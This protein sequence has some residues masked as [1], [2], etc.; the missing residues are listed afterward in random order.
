MTLVLRRYPDDIESLALHAELMSELGRF[1]EARQSVQRVDRSQPTARYVRRMLAR[2]WRG[3]G[4]F[5]KAHDLLTKLLTEQPRDAESSYEMAMLLAT[6]VNSRFH[7]P[8]EALQYARRAL[9]EQPA[10]WAYGQA[11]ALALASDG[12]F[13][14]AVMI[15]KHVVESAPKWAWR[16]CAEQLES[17]RRGQ[18]LPQVVPQFR[19]PTRPVAAV[20]SGE[21][22]GATRFS[23]GQVNTTVAAPAEE[24][25]PAA[26][27]ES[28]RHAV[29][30]AALGVPTQRTDGE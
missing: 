29:D 24:T 12:G 17:Y 13:P 18:I 16:E 25:S 4:E 23:N 14:Q 11:A 6:S 9:R 7:N 8:A 28:V 2:G 1:D 30:E 3:T 10:N 5:E 20:D 27:A 15:Q 19:P 26:D 21:T 22:A